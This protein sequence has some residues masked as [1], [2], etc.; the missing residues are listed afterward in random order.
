MDVKGGVAV[1]VAVE[2][3][4]G[5]EAE[6]MLTLALPRT[7]M[8]VL[9]VVWLLLL[10]SV[11]QLILPTITKRWIFSIMKRRRPSRMT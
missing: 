9:L 1:A 5:A 6:F 3:V 8:M 7:P 10:T 11:G 4:V 2:G